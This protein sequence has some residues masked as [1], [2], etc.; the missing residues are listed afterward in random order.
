MYRRWGSEQ[1]IHS[2]HFA[3]GFEKAVQRR[4]LQNKIGWTDEQIETFQQTIRKEKQENSQAA[5]DLL[6]YLLEKGFSPIE[7]F[8]MQD[9]LKDRAIEIYGDDHFWYFSSIARML[10]Y[11]DDP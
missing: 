4:Y 8:K 3:I 9:T 10:A 2:E 6:T 7:I 5:N 1:K 11:N